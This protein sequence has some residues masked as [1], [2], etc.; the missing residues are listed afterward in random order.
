MSAACGWQSI[1]PEKPNWSGALVRPIDFGLAMKLVSD[2]VCGLVSPRLIDVHAAWKKTA[3]GRMAPRRE[4]ITPALLKSALPWVWMIDVIDRGRD[5]RF[6]L[7]GD[8]IIQF[9]GR[10]YAGLLLS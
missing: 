1:F 3:A 7:A 9:M 10:R 8:R 2:T 6:R 5:F 4:E